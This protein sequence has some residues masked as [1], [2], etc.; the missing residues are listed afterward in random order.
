VYRLKLCI[1]NLV[2]RVFCSHPYNRLV[3]NDCHVARVGRPPFV[4]RS[5]IRFARL[6]DYCTRLQRDEGVAHSVGTFVDAKNWIVRAGNKH[7]V[8]QSLEGCP[9]RRKLAS[10]RRGEAA[11]N[12]LC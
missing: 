11:W 4:V 8:H 12:T 2:R 5:H 3:S 6:D 9:L 10:R 7:H 1:G